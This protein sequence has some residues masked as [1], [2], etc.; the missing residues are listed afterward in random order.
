M[1]E[2]DE[3]A[4]RR[5]FPFSLFLLLIQKNASNPAEAKQE[6]WLKGDPP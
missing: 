1:A 4:C 2:Q 3:M 6:A 5:C